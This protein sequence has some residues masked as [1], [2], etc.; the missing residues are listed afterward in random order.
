MSQERS[1]PDFGSLNTETYN[2]P[3]TIE[4]LNTAISDLNNTAPGPDAIHN[5]ILKHLPTETHLLLLDIF[6]HYWQT[7][8][9]PDSWHHATVI[10]IP[11]PHKDHTNP[12]HYRPIALT[13]C[14]C[15]LMEKLVNKRLMWFLE[16]TNSFSNIQCGFRKNR[17][18][19]DHLVRL[20]TYIRN[21]FINKQHVV[22]IFFDLEK[23]FDTT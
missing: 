8:T 7:H 18:T 12:S 22:A 21:A 19:M 9:F 3:F 11:K 6:N 2:S 14:L 10:P 5:I 4:E 13:S 17:S 15:K 16:T 23:A 20:E 1:P